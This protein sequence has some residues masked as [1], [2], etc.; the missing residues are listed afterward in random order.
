MAFSDQIPTAPALAARIT[1]FN[2]NMDYDAVSA[3]FVAASFYR[4]LRLQRFGDHDV[5]Q[6]PK[7]FRGSKSFLH[8]A[9]S[10]AA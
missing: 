3:D 7:K 1:L 5:G 2:S 9:V 6:L 4:I 10:G 8:T